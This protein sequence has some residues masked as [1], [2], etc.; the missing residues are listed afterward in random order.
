VHEKESSSETPLWDRHLPYVDTTICRPPMNSLRIIPSPP[1]MISLTS[2]FN[3][4]YEPP[5][6]QVFQR[7]SNRGD[8]AGD[9]LP[10]GIHPLGPNHNGSGGNLMGPN[11]PLFH[12]GPNPNPSGFGMM[13]RFDPYG[14]PGG[15]QD[16]KHFDTTGRPIP[17]GGLG[18]P[19]NDIA[20]PPRDL[21]NN[22]FM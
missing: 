20:R 15:P 16:P 9:A 14:P 22:M 4:S 1:S 18:I 6:V 11:H 5:T 19:N 8:F 12:M 3:N 2:P 13:P 17:P 10:L 21:S 7:P